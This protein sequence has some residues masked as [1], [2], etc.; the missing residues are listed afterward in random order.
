MFSR[1]AL[2]IFALTA[3]LVAAQ[4]GCTDTL[5]QNFDEDASTESGSCT[6]SCASLA[7][8]FDMDSPTCIF[9]PFVVESCAPSADCS[10]GY[11]SGTAATPSTTCTTSGCG[12]S[13]ENPGTCNDAGGTSPANRAA[14]EALLV[15]A[16]AVLAADCVAPDGTMACD[17]GDG[18]IESACVLLTDGNSAACSWT[19]RTCAT[20]VYVAPD[21]AGAT[22][23]RCTPTAAVWTTAA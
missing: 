5:A 12:L 16:E 22:S 4:A 13:P 8:H 17:S 2:L 10:T 20:Q 1:H 7:T 21:P 11:V 18:G 14:C 6:Y 9:A 15:T 19:G 3:E 23:E